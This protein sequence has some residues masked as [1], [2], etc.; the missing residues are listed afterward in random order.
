MNVDH[1]IQDISVIIYE[2]PLAKVRDEFDYP[3]LINP[4][5]LAILLIDCDT[6][7]DMNGVLGFLENLNGRYLTNVTD[8]LKKIGAQKSAAVFDSIQV[9]MR[10]H[11]ITWEQLRGDF[12]G[13]NQYEITSFQKLHGSSLDS[14]ANEI[15]EI[16]SGFSLFNS[17]N[18][19]E[20]VYSFF[21]QY[22]EGIADQFEKE[23][24]KR[25]V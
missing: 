14:F 4:L 7:I 6:E 17:N 15:S 8:V 2:E 9:C 12:D 11:N 19:P 24:E 10:K 18:S 23:I 13:A 21:V 16:S 1:V 5:H 20:D 25:M 3:N 22:L